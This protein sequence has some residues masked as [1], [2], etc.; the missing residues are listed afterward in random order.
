MSFLSTRSHE[1]EQQSESATR[2]LKNFYPPAL[3]SGNS[4]VFALVSEVLFLSTR[5][6]ERELDFPY[7]FRVFLYFYPPALTSGNAVLSPDSFQL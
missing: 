4:E 6:H 5:S 1:R 3:T 2:K 7:A